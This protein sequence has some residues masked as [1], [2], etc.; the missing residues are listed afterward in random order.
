MR[1]LLLAYGCSIIS[2]ARGGLLQIFSKELVH[3]GTFPRNVAKEINGIISLRARAD[4]AAMFVS[5]EEAV[6][7]LEVCRKIFQKTKE[8]LSK[9]L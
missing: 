1:S 8:I 7:A 5:R 4:Y 2:K 6:R 9:I 3:K